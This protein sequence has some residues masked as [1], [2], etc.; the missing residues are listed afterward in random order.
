MNSKA[1]D[2]VSG[3][4]KLDAI[5]QYE[6]QSAIRN[7]GHAPIHPLL[8]RSMQCKR[9]PRIAMRPMK[10]TG[11]KSLY[12]GAALGGSELC[13]SSESSLVSMYLPIRAEE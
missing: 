1:A 4:I 9:S 11:D 3:L 5:N 6:K 2:E 13:E 8:C 12:N 7:P 10:I